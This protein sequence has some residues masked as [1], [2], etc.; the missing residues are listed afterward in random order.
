MP[1]R[2]KRKTTKKRCKE[3]RFL[4]TKLFFSY[5]GVH[6]LVMYDMY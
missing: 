1:S 3:R 5:S 2:L 6:A 4:F